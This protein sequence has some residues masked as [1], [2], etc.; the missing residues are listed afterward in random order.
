MTSPAK[1]VDADAE[2]GEAGGVRDAAL[3]SGAEERAELRRRV[4]RARP[5]VGEAQ[6]LELREGREEVARELLPRLGP[7][8]VRGSH[9]AAV[10]VDRVVAAEQDPVVAAE[11]VVVELVRQ[12]ADALPVAPAD[13][14]ELRRRV[15]GSVIST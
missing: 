8:L 3:A 10:V 6:A 4:D 11:P 2:P 15:S 5:L 9:A 14:R 13:R 7:V 12:V 1:R